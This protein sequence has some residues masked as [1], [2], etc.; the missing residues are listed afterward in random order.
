MQP[1][2]PTFEAD[3]QKE[4]DVLNFIIAEA[5]AIHEASVLKAEE[6]GKPIRLDTLRFIMKCSDARLKLLTT[7]A[8]AIKTTKQHLRHYSE[9]IAQG[10]HSSGD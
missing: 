8:P 5:K 10:R 7:H 2:T 4:L 3:L 9:P 1:L 6:E